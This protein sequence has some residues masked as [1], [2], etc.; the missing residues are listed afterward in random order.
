MRVSLQKLLSQILIIAAISIGNLYCSASFASTELRT[1][2]PQSDFD[3]SHNYFVSLLQLMLDNTSSEYGQSKV[4]HVVRMEQGRAFYELKRGEIIDVYWAGTS[5]DREEE[6]TAIRIPLLKG[7]LGYRLS[8]IREDSKSNFQ[9][10]R[11]L[12]DLRKYTAC[13]GRHWP[14]SDILESAGIEV[15][16]G[17]IYELMFGQLAAGRCDFFPRG[18]HEGGPELTARRDKYPNLRLFSDSIV[19]YPFPMYFFVRKGNTKLA[20][21]L[22]LGLERAIDSGEFDQL[23]ENHPITSK[24]FPLTQWGEKN[25]IAIS[26]PLLPRDTPITNSRYWVRPDDLR[27]PAE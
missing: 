2:P 10:I 14:D 27:A 5:I 7:L 24:L 15:R 6:F 11:S 21:R 13:Q 23:L 16:R 20:K 9:E 8:I 4:T 12:E 1:I 26:N 19:Y 17:P 18:I 25:F 22:E 3:V